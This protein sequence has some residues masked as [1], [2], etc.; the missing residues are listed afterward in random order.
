MTAEAYV[1]CWDVLPARFRETELDI[2]ML[3][4]CID[5]K[6]LKI[7]GFEDSRLSERLVT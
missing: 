7:G 6:Y 4:R 5:P 2:E 1:D 3:D